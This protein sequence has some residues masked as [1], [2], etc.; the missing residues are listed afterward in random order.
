MVLNPVKLTA[1]TGHDKQLSFP[2]YQRH[3]GLSVLSG[4]FIGMR[5]RNLSGIRNG[6]KETLGIII[7][8]AEDV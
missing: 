8:C 4:P 7:M 1:K 2:P 6:L 3:K 5:V